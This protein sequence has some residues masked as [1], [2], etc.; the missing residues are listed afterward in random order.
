MRDS[1]H[2]ARQSERKRKTLFLHRSGNLKTQA[3]SSHG[4]QIRP[5]KVQAP[6]ILHIK[7]TKHQFLIQ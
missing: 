7:G 2:R 1:L 4:L 3:S 5:L 6:F